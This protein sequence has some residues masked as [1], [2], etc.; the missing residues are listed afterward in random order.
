MN[1]R[2]AAVPTIVEVAEK[3]GVSIKTVSR[4]LNH[5]ANVKP[6][7]RELVLR[8]VA[9]LNYRP[10]L[11]ARSLAGARSFLL[12]LLYYDP[13]AAFV[14]GMQRGAT[15]RCREA[16]YH[17]VVESFG[18]DAGN[19][20]AQLGHMLGALQPDGM[21]LTP[22]ICDNAEVL[23]AIQASGT[24][25]VLL[26]PGDR[27]AHLPQ[28]RMDEVQ[29]ARELTEL[30]IGLGHRR[31]GFIKG[32]P[33]QAASEWR[34]RGFL[35][36]MRGRGLAVDAA[37]VFDGDFTFPSGQRAAEHLLGLGAP[38]TAVFASNDDTA[39]GFMA[40][41]QRRGLQVPQDVSVVGFDDSPSASLV[42]PA[43]TTVRQPVFEMAVAAVDMLLARV[44][45]VP[46]D[47]RQAPVK[48]LPHELVLRDS[49]AA[50]ARRGRRRA[51]A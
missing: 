19:L 17:L 34:L 5:E 44:G 20:T 15:L 3:A 23:A 10:K 25:C 29:A 1:P 11:S 30:L 24:P 21:I 7:T 42:W 33:E 14:A 8:V 26:S 9:E 36:A 6:E 31:I 46:A 45:G 32:A 38:P 37:C 2:T 16:G 49:T 13:S 51:T 43:L 22:P 39:L 41:A 50:P 18:A 47:E 35:Q 28:V 12:G 40:A 48:V 27:G 4:V